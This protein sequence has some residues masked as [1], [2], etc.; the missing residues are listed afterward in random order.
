MINSTSGPGLLFPKVISFESF[1]L[2][3]YFDENRY[4]FL[5]HSKASLLIKILWSLSSTHT[6]IVEINI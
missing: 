2:K 5:V 6:P 4:L 3:I 1:F